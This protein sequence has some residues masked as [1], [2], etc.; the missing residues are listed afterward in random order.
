L[1][2]HLAV[3]FINGNPYSTM[4]IKIQPCMCVSLPEVLSMKSEFFLSLN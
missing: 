2:M 4:R 3:S 1:S